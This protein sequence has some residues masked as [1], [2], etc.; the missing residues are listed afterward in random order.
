MENRVFNFAAGP[1]AMPLEILE[2]AQKDLVC[3]PGGGCSV[4]EMSHRSKSFQ[5]II[6]RAE[7]TLRRIM[8]IPDDYAV[9][10]LQGGASTQFSAIPMNLTHQGETTNYAV[11]GQFAKKAMDEAARW[12]NAVAVFNGKADNFTQLP[13][14]TPDMLTPDAKYL[15]ITGNNTIFG[16]TYNT[17]PQ[18]GNIPLVADWSSAILGINIDV[19]KY[20][21]IYAGAQKNMGPAGL[22]VVIVKKDAIGEVD[23]IVPTMLRYEPMIKNGSMYNT[24]PCWSIYM[25]GLMF[26]WVERQ[27]GVEE[28][29]KRNQKKAAILYDIIDKSNLFVNPV[30]KADRSIMNV[31]FTLPTD[32]LTTAFLDMCKARKMI[33]VKGHR[34]VGGCRASIYNGVTLEAVEHLAQCM[35]DFEKG[36]RT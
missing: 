8:H 2:Q 4:M 29:E 5:D 3:Y 14:I 17:L 33:N 31:V 27:G 20:T 11:T 7:A 18:T 32:E 23:N 16:T 1:S 36:Q 21:L 6:D 10:F 24:P 9:L 34:A 13:V 15:H 30:N 26:D 19:T 22:T 35:V 12:G 28:M 25:S